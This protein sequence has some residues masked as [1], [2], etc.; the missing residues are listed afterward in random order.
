[1]INHLRLGPEGRGLPGRGLGRL[2]LGRAGKGQQSYKAKISQSEVESGV[3]HFDAAAQP[4]REETT[5]LIPGLA[6]TRIAWALPRKSLSAEGSP[7][8]NYLPPRN[9][10]RA[11]ENEAS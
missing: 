8:Q 4:G 10:Q 5:Y 3:F 6:D 11:W 7:R 1:M 2:P 9:T